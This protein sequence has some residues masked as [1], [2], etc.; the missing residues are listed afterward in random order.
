MLGF[1]VAVGSSLGSEVEVGCELGFHV[2]VGCALG[3]SDG[4]VLG[5]SE[6]GN[7]TVGMEV[8][9]IRGPNGMPLPLPAVMLPP[10]LPTVLFAALLLPPNP[11]KPR[12]RL[13]TDLAGTTEPC[14][15]PV[16]NAITS[17][18]KAGTR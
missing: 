5:M 4:I 8:C 7:D 6:G 12:E 16:V 1:Q 3:T 13:F 9:S 17:V 18:V 10:P 14:F 15:N 2:E 11:F